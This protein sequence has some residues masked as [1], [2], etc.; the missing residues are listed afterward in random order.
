L[1]VLC[2]QTRW[3]A[4]LIAFALRRRRTGPVRVPP[5]RRLTVVV[6]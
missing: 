1:R 6:E 4:S 5:S 3:R 2:W